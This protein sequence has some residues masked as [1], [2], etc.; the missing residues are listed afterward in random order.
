LNTFVNS[1]RILMV[2]RSLI[3]HVLPRFIFSMGCRCLR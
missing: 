3:L 2:A 1:M